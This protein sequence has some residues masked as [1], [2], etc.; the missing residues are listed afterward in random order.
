MMLIASMFT[1]LVFAQAEAVLGDRVVVSINNIPYTQLQVEGYVN[2]KETLRKDIEN[3]LP[4]SQDNWQIALAAFILDMV[5]YQEANKSSGFRPQSEGVQKSL[6]IVK[7]SLAKS[8]TFSNRFQK[9]GIDDQLIKEHLSRILTLEN[10][11][12]S[13]KSFS[14]EKDSNN[15]WEEDLQKNSL[16]RWYDN[17]KIYKN[18]TSMPLK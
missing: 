12:R 1:P 9:L 14:R 11:R 10:L 17:G 16:V 4:V 7:S 13:R 15:N 6:E 18:L 5:V 8:P 3:S 2:V